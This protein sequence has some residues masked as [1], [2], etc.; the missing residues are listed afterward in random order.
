[1]G[2]DDVHQV[3]SGKQEEPPGNKG[4]CEGIDDVELP[5]G[6]VENPPATLHCLVTDK[7]DSRIGKKDA[8]SG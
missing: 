1:M 4:K 6:N 7:P 3:L 2:P 5:R 8:D